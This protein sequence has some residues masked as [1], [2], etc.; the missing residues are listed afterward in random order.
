MVRLFFL[1]S[2]QACPEGK[3][4]FNIKKK[5]SLQQYCQACEALHRAQAT[6]IHHPSVEDR[7]GWEVAKRQF[8]LW[9]DLQEWIKSSYQSLQYHK[10]GKRAGKLLARLCWGP[11]KPTHIMALGGCT[12]ALKSS[13]REIAT[14]FT[15]YYRA[16]YY[17]DPIEPDRATSVLASLRLPTL[18]RAQLELWMCLSPS[19]PEVL[20]IKHLANNKAL[21]PDGYSAEFYKLTKD[22]VP[23]TLL[24]VGGDP[25]SSCGFSGAQQA[26]GQEGGRTQLYRASI[27][28]FI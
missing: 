25:L 1:G 2:R 26:A 4:P 22:F 13:S 9:A 10:Y 5:H 6:L 27:P 8:Y 16:L 11:H 18:S 23:E 17:D 19:L 21:G 3:Y 20:S 24:H 15:D 28:P 7:C 14:L 12:S